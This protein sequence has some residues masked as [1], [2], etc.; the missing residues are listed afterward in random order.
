MPKGVAGVF[1][2]PFKGIYEEIQK[3]HGR[4]V[5]SHIRAMLILEGYNQVKDL[6][7]E[8]RLA[9]LEQWRSLDVKRGKRRT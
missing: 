2:L 6:T 9:I 7:D 4:T 1:G 5:D 8:E 3:K